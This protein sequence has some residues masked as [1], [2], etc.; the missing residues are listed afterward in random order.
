MTINGEPEVMIKH[1]SFLLR[2]AGFFGLG[3]SVKQGAR[4][5]I[6]FELA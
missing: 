4:G 3:E 5:T 2:G 6:E 1:E